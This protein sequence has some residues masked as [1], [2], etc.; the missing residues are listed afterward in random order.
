MKERVISAVVMISIVVACFFISPVTRA[1]F[2][3][4]FII[5]A[6]REMCNAVSNKDI[7]CPRWILYIYTAAALALIFFKVD[8]LIC[9]ALFFLAIFAVTSAGVL[10]KDI[11][12]PGALMSLAILI[13]PIVPM[14]IIS[15]LALKDCWVPV[16]AIGC[17]TTWVCDSF[18]LFGGKRFGKNKLAPEVS[19][20]KTIEGSIC[21]A[22]SAVVAGAIISFFIDVPLLCCMITSL[23]ASSMGQMGDLVASLVKRWAG[24]KDYSNL[25]P[26]HGGAMDRVDSLLFSI[27]CTYFCFMIAGVI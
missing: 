7:K 9:E 26:G 15:D 16:F 1:I 20:K 18:A 5:L 27:P 3:L 19:P 21:G 4:A 8:A 17:I 11:R 13:Y 10:K 24:I 14:L 25:I 6:V 12:A 23:I 22:I 2:L